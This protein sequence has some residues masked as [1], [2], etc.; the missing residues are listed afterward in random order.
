MLN[1]S[2]RTAYCFDYSTL[3]PRHRVTS[4][5]GASV[6]WTASEHF[7]IV[8]R[9]KHFDEL[10]QCTLLS[11]FLRARNCWS[12]AQVLYL[13]TWWKTFSDYETVVMWPSRV[14]IKIVWAD[15][16]SV[17]RN[18]SVSFATFVMFVFFFCVRL[19]STTHNTTCFYIGLT[20]VAQLFF[21]KSN[22]TFACSTSGIVLSYRETQKPECS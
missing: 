4:T 19:I 15:K 7:G 9:I 11:F 1:V 20:V 14:E 12:H 3:S 5:W 22:K 18:I 10:A 13:Y 17:I 2:H 16:S 21:L 6:L 8:I